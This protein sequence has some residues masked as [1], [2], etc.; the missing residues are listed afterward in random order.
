M[1][2]KSAPVV[3]RTRPGE[4]ST[5]RSESGSGTAI[6]VAIMFPALMLVI[7]TLHGI[8]Y[9]TRSEQAL[10]VVADRAAHVGSLC[11]L[12]V[13]DARTAVSA[14]IAVH[15]NSALGSRLECSNDV[16]ADVLVFF[17]D[18]N[19]ANVPELDADDNP[20][21]V[22]AGGQVIVSVDCQLLPSRLGT[23]TLLASDVHRR[24]V[25]VATVDPYRHRFAPTG[26]S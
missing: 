24:A 9:A 2:R 22:P 1:L 26:V 21:L 8:T 4:N 15:A 5:A 11:C 12:H 3:L 18:V 13:G 16:T 7:V 23:F 25:G 19:H 14:S 10:Q 17:E 20:N 6:G